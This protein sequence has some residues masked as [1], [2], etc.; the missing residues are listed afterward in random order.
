MVR[1]GYHASHEQFPPSELLSYVRAAEAA[2]FEAVMCSD[3]FA[4]WSAKHQGQSGFAWS[5]LGA[6]MA[7]TRV[8]F[9][10]V[11]TPVGWRYH[12]AVIAQAAATLEEMFPGRFWMAL[13]S[14]EA[15]NEHIVGDRWPSKAERNERLLEAVDVM[16]RLFAGQTVSRRGHIVVDRARLY[17]RPEEPPGMIGAALSPP[18]SALHATWAEGLATINFPREELERIVGAFRENGGARKPVRLQVHL[19]YAETEAEALRNAM[20]QW[21]VNAVPRL[22]TENL[23]TTEEY[24][25]LYG[26]VRE[27]DVRKSVFISS[28]PKEHVRYLEGLM[29]L[30]FESVYLHNVG[31]NQR[32]FIEVF[33]DEVLPKLRE[34]RP[35]LT[36]S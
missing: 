12:P 31:R 18:T 4:P 35:A 32:E 2:G 26:L 3:H 22:L 19:S 5:W 24:D 34:R 30:G 6:A 36:V 20:D 23:Q 7:T 9:G 14:G 21:A 15:M 25:A 11:T 1:I 27:E 13:G 10:V 29:D 28:D 17:T 8:P 33:G 16:R